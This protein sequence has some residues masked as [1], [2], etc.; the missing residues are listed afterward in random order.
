MDNTNKISF[1]WILMLVH[2]EKGTRPWLIWCEGQIH[3][4]LIKKWRE[5]FIANN[6][7]LIPLDVNSNHLQCE[8]D[9]LDENL[10]C[11]FIAS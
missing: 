10:D 8:Q 7:T 5:N 4:T 6:K 9:C 11:T 2:V 1:C 3:Y